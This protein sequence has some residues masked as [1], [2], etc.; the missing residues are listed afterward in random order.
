MD[1]RHLP[2]LKGLARHPYFLECDGRLITQPGYDKVSKMFGVFDPHQFELPGPTKEF[3]VE[4]LGLLKDLL[5]EFRFVSDAD[6]SAALSAMFT[7]VVRPSL[8]HAPGYHVRAPSSGS[9][10]TYLCELIGAFAGPASNSKVSFPRT[11]EEASKVLL[12]LLLTNPAVIEFDDLDSD[13]IPHGV[14]NRALT[15]EHITERILGIS[16]TATVSTRSLFLGSGNNVGPVRDLLRRVLTVN[17]DPRCATPA[18]IRYTGSPVNEVRNN[19]GRY[20]TAVL[21]IIQAWRKD[22]SPRADV[23][24]IATYSGPWGDLCRH[25]LLWL[26]LPDPATSLLNQINHDPDAE[27][28]GRLLLEWHK[29]F[30][31]TPTTVR[32]ALA[33][34]PNYIDDDGNDLKDAIREFPVEER[35]HI[36]RSKF[37]WVLKR[38]ANR[39]VN[40]LEFR[41][42]EADGRTAWMVVEVG[43]P[44]P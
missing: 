17:I 13:W 30:G 28:L 38:N 19:R 43:T 14:I 42:A 20:V 33:H 41:R 7:A 4:S 12:S 40:G 24:N 34:D 37:G 15:A 5:L 35:G 32:K 27:A 18:T 9:G 44:S 3:A 39:I 8:P 36:N 11:S 1:Y 16:K 26:G 10:K 31:S 6:K 22:G 23:E 25:P 2:S 29:A 21:T